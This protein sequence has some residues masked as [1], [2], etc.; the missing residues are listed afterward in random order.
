LTGR[1]VL[2]YTILYTTPVTSPN[3]TGSEAMEFNKDMEAWQN[4]KQSKIT[5]KRL[6][7]TAPDALFVS[8]RGVIFF[9]DAV[10]WWHWEITC[11]YYGGNFSLKEMEK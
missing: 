6:T 4:K 11:Q 7:K 1:K 2:L 8:G 9:R 5:T 10:Q 3:K